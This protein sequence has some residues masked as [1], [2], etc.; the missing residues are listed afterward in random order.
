MPVAVKKDT[1]ERIRMYCHK[2]ETHDSLINR[3]I[4]RFENEKIEINISGKTVNRLLDF[5]GCGNI[6]EAIAILM[7]RYKNIKK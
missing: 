6:D 7:D 1:V 3:I 2:G 5:T 4:D